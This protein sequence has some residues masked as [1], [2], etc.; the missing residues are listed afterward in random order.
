MARMAA[1]ARSFA[2]RDDAGRAFFS[3]FAQLVGWIAF[4]KALVAALD[5]GTGMPAVSAS[6]R[7]FQAALSE[8]RARAQRAGAIRGDVDDDD[9]VALLT[10][11]VAMVAVRGS[12][13]RMVA[14]ACAAL[15][16]DAAGPLPASV[17]KAGTGTSDSNVSRPDERNENNRRA[18]GRCAV[19]GQPLPVPV[20]GRPRRFCGAA[21][22]QKA[23]RQRT[24]TAARFAP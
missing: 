15:R 3:F 24:K 4:N 14:L 23:H 5:R 7:E 19:C 12:A 13:D 20:R 10:G 17:T 21:C 11:C 16:P 18:D 9:V 6:K 8:L 22:R 2:A 1:A